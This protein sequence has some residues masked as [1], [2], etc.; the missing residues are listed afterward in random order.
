VGD[1][2]DLP[3]WWD[4]F[5]NAGP[6]ERERLLKPET[7]PGKRRR[8]RGRGRK[9]SG[10]VAAPGTDGPSGNDAPADA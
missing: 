3:A 10:D 6:D 2:A 5:A 8:S 1:L 7:G 4:R 9:R